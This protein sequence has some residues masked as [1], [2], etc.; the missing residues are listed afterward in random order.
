MDFDTLLDRLWFADFEVFAHDWLLV[1]INYRTGEE[2]VFHNSSLQ[3]VKDWLERVNPILC[4]HNFAYYDKYILKGILCGFEPEQLKDLN[5]FIISGNQGFEYDFNGEHPKLPAIWDTMQDIVPAKSL[6]E[7]EGCLCLDI[8]ESTLPF[9][10][11]TK[12]TPEQYNEVLYY[13]EHDVQALRPLFD[14]RFDYFETKFDLCMLCK[15]C[16]PEYDIGLTNAKLCAKFLEAKL[17]TRDDERDYKIPDSIEL[18]YVDDRIIDFFN[19]IHDSSIP[20]DKLFSTKL[21]IEE[22]GMP[23]VVSWGGKHGSLLKFT[24][25]QENEP[26]MVVINC[27]FASLYPH[28]LALPQ[29]NFIS[30]NIKDKN[31]Y[32]NTLKHR[33]ELKKQGKKKE[34]QALKLILNTTYGCELNQ[35]NDLYDPR[36]ARGT[37]ITGQLLISELTEKVYRIG[38]VQLIQVNTD[39]LMV[40]LPRNKLD[41]YYKVCD[42]FSKKCGIELEYDIISKI[43]QRDVNNYVMLYGDEKHQN[44]KAKGGCFGGA[45]KITINEDGTLST[46]YGVDFKQNTMTICAES[47]IKNLLFDTPVEETINNCD[48]IF[49]F[50]MISHLGHTYQK[51]VLRHKDGSE[52]ELQRNNRIYAGKEKT[53]GKIYKVKSDGRH[54]SLANCPPNPIVDNKNT[55]TIEEINKMWYIKYTLQKINDFKGEKEIFMEEKLDKLKKE[56]LIEKVKELQEKVEGD[57]GMFSFTSNS[58]SLLKK[59]NKFRELIRQRNFVLDKELPK[60]LGN[61]E[62]YSI[63]QI[64]QAVQDTAMEVG[65]DFSFEVTELERLDLE[66]FKPATGAPQHISTIKCLI[67]FTDIDTGAEKIY[68][69]ISQGSDSIDKSVNGASSYAFRNWFN[70]NFTPKIINGEK[71]SF[72]EEGNNFSVDTVESEEVKSTPRT[73]T[74]IPPEKKEELVKEITSTNS[75]E[76]KSEAKQSDVDKLTNLIYEYRELS[77]REDAGANKLDKI[78]N[79]DYTDMDLLNWTLNFENAIND[80]KSNNE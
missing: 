77:G 1:C 78:I 9:D 43:I 40:K 36:G 10:L 66:A 16:N 50:Q 41:A 61:G 26:D 5:D 12:W 56:E 6:K 32:A 51:C 2:I 73:P 42:E 58:T 79:K 11:P 55:T 37:C 24:F 60:N 53:G 75:A 28:L 22:H 34:Q 21:E 23:T 7:I 4:G 8:T 80:L 35:Y 76:V 18:E 3:E 49:R 65:L 19:R 39:G 29:Y 27:D 54:D 44:I 69:M 57:S 47:M 74:F 31:A 38:D 68:Q 46:E 62:I 15:E 14:A 64:Y 33:L 72:G 25:I 17:V 20:S 30:R 52:E 70:K 45:P 71:I 67:T 59:I 13:C 63:D 48:D